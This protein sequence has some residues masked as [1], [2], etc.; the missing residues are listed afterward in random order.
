[1]LPNRDKVSL[2]GSPFVRT[3]RLKLRFIFHQSLRGQKRNGKV[4]ECKECN[5]AKS[6]NYYSSEGHWRGLLVGLTQPIHPTGGPQTECLPKLMSKLVRHL[7]RDSK[8]H[9]STKVSDLYTSR[10]QYVHGCVCMEKTECDERAHNQSRESPG[11]DS[12]GCPPCPPQEDESVFLYR[13]FLSARL[14]LEKSSNKTVL[15]CN[16]H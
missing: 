10:Q 11:A 4:G 2:L 8:S 3:P 12:R 5:Q 14:Y 9:P 15:R 13:R 1:M 16:R 6:F 7:G